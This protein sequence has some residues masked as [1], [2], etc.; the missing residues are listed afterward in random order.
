MGG[1]TVR[2]DPVNKGQHPALASSNL[3]A[4]I[5]ESR[6]QIQH[7]N[8][9]KQD[10]RNFMKQEEQLISF[11]S[12]VPRFQSIAS[13]QIRVLPAS[14]AKTTNIDFIMKRDISQVG[15]GSYTSPENKN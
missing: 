4:S 3:E 14:D 13:H 12:A 7:N 9:V 15:P 8:K 10:L 11:S 1:S 2:H 5:L 6:D